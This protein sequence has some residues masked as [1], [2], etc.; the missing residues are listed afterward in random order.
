MG[1]SEATDM[2]TSRKQ[3]TDA[4]LEEAVDAVALKLHASRAKHGTG[5]YVSTHEV[6]GVLAEEVAEVFGAM[7]DNN[8]AEVKAELVDVVVAALWGIASINSW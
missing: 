6:F 8:I 3:V 1:S 4:A 2:G 5:V 7:K